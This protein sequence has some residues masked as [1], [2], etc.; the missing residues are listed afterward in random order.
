MRM[1][2]LNHP[3]SMG[4]TLDLTSTGVDYGPGFNPKCIFGFHHFKFLGAYNFNYD[5]TNT[6]LGNYSVYN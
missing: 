1:G 5:F 3:Y 4:S 6:M 2:Y